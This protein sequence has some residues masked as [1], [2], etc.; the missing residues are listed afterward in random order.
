LVKDAKT[1]KLSEY[2]KTDIFMKLPTDED[3]L[4]IL[5]KG[6]VKATKNNDE[7]AVF[8]SLSDKEQEAILVKGGINDW[9]LKK[10]SGAF[11]NKKEVSANNVVSIENNKTEKAGDALKK[12]VLGVN[13]IQDKDKV[14]DEFLEGPKPPPGTKL[15]PPDETPFGPEKPSTEVLDHL[16]D[17]EKP[18]TGA[19]TGGIAG[20]KEMRD[21]IQK[22]K[23]TP[24]DLMKLG[25]D[26]LKED[27]T[28][29][30]YIRIP[31]VAK[32]LKKRGFSAYMGDDG[33]LLKLDSFIE[34]APK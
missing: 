31:K 21:I 2:D 27:V 15:Q 34:G 23:A 28:M 17:E 12:N 11:A 19:K 26:L 4:G 1:K 18:V 9:E 6:G 10:A 20:Y 29:A 22:V 33:K 24:N 8:H 30:D 5:R 3:R 25:K 14:L 13:H 32:E 16:L 7:F